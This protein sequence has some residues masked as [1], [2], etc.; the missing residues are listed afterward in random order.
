MLRD[1]R[2]LLVAFLVPVLTIWVYG[3]V[4]PPA[5]ARFD[6]ELF[7][8][9][10]PTSLV[11]SLAVMF[12][13]LMLASGAVVRERGQGTLDR[14]LVTPMHPAGFLAAKLAVLA[15]LAFLQTLLVLFVALT[16]LD[17]ITVQDPV[18][19]IGRLNLVALA[20]LSLGLFVS[21]VSRNE[22]QALL[23]V[24]LLVLV[25]LVLSGFLAPLD[26]LGPLQPLA[27]MLPYTHAYLGTY[28]HLKGLDAPDP[29]WALLALDAVL[30]F[31]AAALLLRRTSRTS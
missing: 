28:H 15:A 22:S 19:T 27:R 5:E 25:M 7:R 12:P 29:Y 21:T 30:A 14:L 10:D 1:R 23:V 24:T 31:G 18:G 11:V 16:A 17:N 13:A 3:F 8:T 4:E 20:F 26:G 6:A 2:A 9:T